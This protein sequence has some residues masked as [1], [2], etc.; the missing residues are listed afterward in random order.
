M[1]LSDQK[2][3][4]DLNDPYDL[5]RF[6]RAQEPDYARALSELRA[7]QKQSHWMWYVF[8]QIE[9]LGASTMSRRYSIKSAA[10]ARAYL[11]HPLLGARLREC[12]A[13]VL[14][15]EGRSALQIFGSPDDLKLRSCATLF[16]AVSG[17]A[18][19]GNVIKKYFS[20]QHDPETLSILPT[21]PG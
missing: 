14:N 18:V 15:I 6:V 16:A 17:E 20:G 2:K 21:Q 13:A 10:E 11:D 1:E 4:P 5:D 19:F 9:G 8:P 12:F 7:G 3:P